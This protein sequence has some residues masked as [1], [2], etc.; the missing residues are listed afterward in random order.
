VLPV[1]AGKPGTHLCTVSILGEGI[2]CEPA[3]V[4]VSV[5]EPLLVAKVAGPARCLVRSEPV[6]NFDLSNPGTASTDPITAWAVVPDGFEIATISD[7]GQFNAA[8]RTVGWKLPALPANGSKT[9]SLKLKAAGPADGAVRFVAQATPVAG[10]VTPASFG[11]TGRV[12]EAKAEQVVRAEG[13][14]A[15]RFE[16]LDV[17]DPVEVGKD[18]VYEIKVVNQ[19]TAP[20]TG[21]VVLA[22]LADGTSVSGASG[23]TAGRG[24]GQQVSFDP[25]TTLAPKQE[26][27]Y[28]VRVKGAVPGDMRFR[29]TLSSDQMKAPVVKEESTRFYKD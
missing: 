20:C 27:I 19:G 2:V 10:P 18:A 8:N 22:A 1:T 29:V 17:D 16:V 5:V 14:P 12:L 4:A 26:V 15:L 3:K 9:L 7:G 11:P 23:P 24:Q 6:Y 21:V 25:L 28:Q 13:V